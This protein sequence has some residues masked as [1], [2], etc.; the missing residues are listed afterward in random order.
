MSPAEIERIAAS[1]KVSRTIDIVAPIGGSITQKG[2][3]QGSFVQPGTSLFEITDLSRVWALADIS[4]YEAGRV[5]P[6]Q[7]ATL[8]LTAFPGQRFTGKVGFIY[9]ALD[10][11]T[12]TLR[13]RLELDNRRRQ[14]R[15]GMY[16]ELTIELT[17]AR[18]VVVPRDALVAT[19]DH[20]YVFVAKDGG[21][22]EPRLVTAGARSADKVQIL[23]GLAGGELV[24]TTA[25]CLIDSESRLRAA[26]AGSAH[27]EGR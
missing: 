23:E 27:A 3:T 12:R 18:G 6:G 9:P 17:R 25:N 20:Q 22:F 5:A 10:A 14:L 15:P 4:E 19:G 26:I 13:V 2:A 8:A 24:V 7:S 21:H 16:G 11:S 1:G